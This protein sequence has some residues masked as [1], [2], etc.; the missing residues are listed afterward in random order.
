MTEN[1]HSKHRERMRAKYR[2]AGLDAFHDHEVLEILLYYCYPRQD[3]NPMAHKILKEFKTLQN[4]FEANT[5]TIM[6]RIGCTE[7]VAVLLS[8]MPAVA[9][10]YLQ[11]KWQDKIFLT[12]AFT[13]GE[14]VTSLFV[15][16]NIETFYALCLDNQY[17][18]NQV[19]KIAQGTV[20][21]VPVFIRELVKKALEYQ[22]AYIIVA[23]NHPGGSIIP[24]HSD[25]ILTSRI[26][27]ALELM[28]IPLT[29][30]II[31]A[32]DKFFSFAQR[33]GNKH[34]IGY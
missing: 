24:S 23:H 34:V 14:Y 30:H 22:A 9:K 5:E 1:I 26:R 31:A 21:E 29:D 28:D 16:E 17:R 6:A 13:T 12:D 10:R 20:N 4:L 19:V 18:L 11:S 32:G 2:K 7:K 27:D 15:G 3:T 8:L 33:E 25:N